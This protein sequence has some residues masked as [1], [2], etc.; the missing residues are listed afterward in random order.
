MLQKI[1]IEIIE[2]LRYLL[3]DLEDVVYKE[4]LAPLHYHSVGQHVRHITEFYQCLLK[5]YETGEV[6]Y[7]AR[8]RNLRIEVDKTFALEVITAVKSR[9]NFYQNDKQLILQTAFG[10]EDAI[11]IPS[12]FFRELTYLIEHTIHHL[13]IIKIGLNEVY[14]EIQIAPDFGVAHSTIKHRNMQNA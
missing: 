8:E 11:S 6:N 13:A 14:P 10:L 4:S 7:D 3:E 2:Q 12:S 5:G 9:L 1:N